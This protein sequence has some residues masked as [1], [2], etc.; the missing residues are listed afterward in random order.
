MQNSG[1]RVEKQNK[2]PTLGHDL[3]SSNAK[4]LT[5]KEHNSVTV[6]S[7]Q[8]FHN[9]TL[10]I[11]FLRENKVFA[12]L[13]STCALHIFLGLPQAKHAA[14]FTFPKIY[15]LD[16]TMEVAQMRAEDGTFQR[17]TVNK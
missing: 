7:F 2:I 15:A 6:F 14:C 5:K 9:C 16:L 1:P 12:N 13:Y 17:C 4:I 3:P 11:F 10:T 8:I